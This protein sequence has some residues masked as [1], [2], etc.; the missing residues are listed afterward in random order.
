MTTFLPCLA[1][2]ALTRVVAVYV[3]VAIIMCDPL[4]AKLGGRRAAAAVYR[5][6]G[7][8]TTQEESI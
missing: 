6:I 5:I 7:T 1:I 2:L 4:R 8:D 3:L